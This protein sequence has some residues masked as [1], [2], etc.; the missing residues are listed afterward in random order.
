[1]FAKSKKLPHKLKHK[2]PPV[3]EGQA[4]PFFDM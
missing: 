4:S 2:K 3:R 1:M